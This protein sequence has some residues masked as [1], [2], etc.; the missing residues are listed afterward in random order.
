MPRILI[1]D[2]DKDVRA[3]IQVLLE[4]QGFE[5]VVVESGR[6]AIEVAATAPIDA[7]IVDIV[8]PGMDGL[9]TIKAFDRSAPGVPVVA[10]SGFMFR[11]T[12]APLPDFLGVA[13]TLGA[14]CSLQKPFRPIALLEALE[15]CLSQGRHRL[16]A[17][18]AA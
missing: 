18:P 9:E 17:A 7:A 16:E 4:H 15:S 14:A 2:D 3:A 10:I 11:D 5:V 6:S 8:M 12:S 13:K 1:V